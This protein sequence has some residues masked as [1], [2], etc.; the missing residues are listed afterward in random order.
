MTNVF[1]RTRQRRSYRQKKRRLC[2]QRGREW[3][4]PVPSKGRLEP[5]E[6]GRGRMDSPGAF[7]EVWPYPR[8]DLGLVQNHERI[9]ISCF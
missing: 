1:K 5:L 7:R 8:L 6:A 2:G 4:H 3:S 9:H